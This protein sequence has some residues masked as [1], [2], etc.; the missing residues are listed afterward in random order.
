VE[1]ELL[2]VKAIEDKLQVVTDRTSRTHLVLFGM[3]N[4][5][6]WAP[7][8]RREFSG[9]DDKQLLGVPC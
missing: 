5:G 1:L 2:G 4:R 8:I 6:G 7:L 3:Q 9:I